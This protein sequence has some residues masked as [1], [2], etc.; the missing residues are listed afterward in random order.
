[1]IIKLPLLGYITNTL[2]FQAGFV[3]SQ[4]KQLCCSKGAGREGD[5]RGEEP[6]DGHSTTADGLHFIPASHSAHVMEW[7]RQRSDL[8]VSKCTKTSAASTVT[9]KRHSQHCRSRTMLRAVLINKHLPVSS[10]GTSVHFSKF[11]PSTAHKSDTQ[12]NPDSS[13][14]GGSCW[15]P[16]RPIAAISSLQPT[17]TPAVSDRSALLLY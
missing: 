15:K 3:C 2:C 6:R 11:S 16:P 12:H 14:S 13:V 8:T 5:L 7:H 4:V 17:C 9:G 10:S 1:M